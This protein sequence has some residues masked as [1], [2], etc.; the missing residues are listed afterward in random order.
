MF[1]PRGICTRTR[2]RMNER[3]TENKKHGHNISIISMISMK[4]V[5]PRL[6]RNNHRLLFIGDYFS[7]L[8][9]TPL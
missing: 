2:E 4:V 6:S 7:T 5:L 9:R 1:K 8:D 3:G